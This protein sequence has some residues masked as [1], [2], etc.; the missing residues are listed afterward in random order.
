M[1]SADY[2]GTYILLMQISSYVEIELLVRELYQG[3]IT[4]DAFDPL[5]KQLVNKLET[6]N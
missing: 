5:F 3:K 2:L 6:E 1:I 4:R